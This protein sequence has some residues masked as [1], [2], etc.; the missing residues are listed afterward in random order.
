MRAHVFTDSALRKHA[1]RFVWLSIDTEKEANA[2]FVEKFP[3]ENWPTLLVLDS[4][5]ERPVFKWP[6][7]A[8]AAQLEKMFTD[9]EGALKGESRLAEADRL[10]AERRYTEAA[11]AYEQVLASVPPEFDRRARAVESLTLAL[12][13]SKRYAECSDVAAREVAKIPKGPSFANTAAMGLFCAQSVKGPEAKQKALAIKPF[14]LEALK[15]EGILADDRSGLYDALI[16][17]AE[18]EGDNARVKTLSAEWFSFLEA[19]WKA[20]SSP[21]A[22][23]AFDPHLVA[24]AQRINAPERA[25]PML[26]AS[27]AALPAD[28]N[29]PARL[30]LL[31]REMGRFDDAIAAHDRALAKVYGPRRLVVMEQK[32]QTLIKKGD[33]AAARAV[34]EEARKIAGA[35]P[36]TASIDRTIARIDKA[37]GEL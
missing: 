27:E 25:V 18:D 4:S 8:T 30:A 20:A 35:M 32:A 22:R 10:N 19:Q 7:S 33:R 9:A 15:L 36:K 24:A 3:I 6:G 1:G 37:L 29:A 23:A 17:L 12:Y 28:Y 2:R 13:Q 34:Y 31:Y 11:A 21:E 26:V 16:Q 14:A 5:S